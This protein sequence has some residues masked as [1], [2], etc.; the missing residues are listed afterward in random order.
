M[1]AV[2]KT[3]QK[4]EQDL[5]HCKDDRCQR[6]Q[7]VIKDTP[8]VLRHPSKKAKTSVAGRV[9]NPALVPEARHP[10]QHCRYLENMFLS[11]IGGVGKVRLSGSWPLAGRKPGHSRSEF[12]GTGSS[13]EVPTGR[14]TP[15]WPRPSWLAWRGR[16]AGSPAAA[17]AAPSLFRGLPS[18]SMS[19]FL[20]FHT[21]TLRPTPFQKFCSVI[22]ARARVPSSRER[23]GSY[24]P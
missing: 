11:L 16:P 7:P 17:G 4:K 6:I 19:F 23:P 24:T 5:L 8:P 10:R 1:V 15:R 2:Q 18:F 13:G 20:R 22:L 9:F 21:Y 14:C 12:G 3:Q